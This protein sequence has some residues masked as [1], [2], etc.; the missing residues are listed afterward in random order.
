MSDIKPD[1][2]NARKHSERNAAMVRQSL[3]EVGPFRSI[4]VDGDDIIRAGNLTYQEAE[5]LGLKMRVV[6]AAPD[7]LIVVKRPDLQGDAAKR[8]ALWDNRTSDP[9]VGSEWDAKVIARIQQRDAALLAGVFERDEVAEILALAKAQHEP[10]ADPGAQIDRAGELQE[11]WGTALG[12]AWEVGR[13][14]VMCG[15]SMSVE[16]I[17][18]LV[19]GNK[20]A[21][22]VTSP[23]YFVGKEYERQKTESQIVEF[24]D[25]IVARCDEVTSTDRRI[26]INCAT[27]P[28]SHIGGEIDY[29]LNLDW[30]QRALRI[31]GWLSRSIRIW[32]KHGGLVH[33][34]PNADIVDMHWEYLATF[35]HPQ[36]KYR[37]QNRVDE[38]WATSGIWDDIHGAKQDLHSA[39]YP[40]VIPERF[41]LL[42]TDEGENVFDPFLGSGTTLVA[43][44]QTGR[45][46]YGMEI[47]PKYVA[48]TLER[49]SQMGLEP[50]LVEQ[51]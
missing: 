17:G 48:V 24:I 27:T 21:L 38:G 37:G 43:C 33:N 14:R 8:A 3:E 22:T 42:Y 41:V 26:V 15:D 18:E 44:E 50:R 35:Y 19:G 4:A 30:W 45:T 12:Q 25:N 39:P 5:K 20:V 31:R 28:W 16:D 6:E 34:A 9:D 7:E 2:E 29:H 40:L 11:K 49:L 32:A 46:G 1:P 10:V 13:H 51:R 47:E 23:P 36:G